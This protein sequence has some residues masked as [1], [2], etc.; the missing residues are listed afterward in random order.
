MLASKS[1]GASHLLFSAFHR[2]DKRARARTM[3]HNVPESKI[4]E[5]MSTYGI[6]GS[7]LPT[8]MGGEIEFSQSEWIEE[9]RV[10]EMEESEI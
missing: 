3:F 2:T 9:R 8:E 4:V 1:D 7:M 5:K 6:L 10:A